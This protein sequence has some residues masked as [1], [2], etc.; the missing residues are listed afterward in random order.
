M[1]LFYCC[2]F[3]FL[4][5]NSTSAQTAIDWQNR[6]G[7]SDWES[8]KSIAPTDD[9]GYIMA[10]YSYSDDN[11]L[12][13]NGDHDFYVVKMDADGQLQWQKN[14]GGTAQ[15]NASDA[16]QTPDGG[17]IVVGRSM[18]NN[19]DMPGNQGAS[20][21][22]LVKLDSTGEMVWQR[23]YGSTG[24][25]EVHA[26]LVTS[27][28]GYVI[29][30]GAN[31]GNG[32]VTGHHG[33]LDAWV[34]KLDADGDVEWDRAYGG[35]ATDFGKD[36]KA[37][38]DGGYILLGT[39][40]ST[41]GDVTCGLS[42]S[43]MWVVKVD[44]TG[45]VQWDVC[46]GSPLGNMAHEIQ[47]TADGG[48]IGIGYVQGIGDDVTEVFGGKDI[49][50]FKLDSA[51]TLEWERSIG[52]AGDDQGHSI[53][54]TWDGGY[55]AVGEYAE[56]P[57]NSSG[58]GIFKLG[59]TG[60][61]EWSQF[62][63]LETNAIAF[64]VLALPDGDFVVAGQGDP[65]IPPDNGMDFWVVKLTTEYNNILGHVFIDLNSDGLHDS[66][67]PSLTNH[68]IHETTSDRF[69]LSDLN[70]DY[71]L[72]VLGPGTFPTSPGPLAHYS[73][74]PTVHSITFAGVNEVDANNDFAFQPDSM[75]HDLQISLV[76]ASAFRPG[77][78]AF[79]NVYFKNV[80][81]V[82]SSG[83]VVLIL[84]SLFTF[85]DAT[86]TPVT[87]AGDSIIWEIP[88][89]TPFETG[90]FVVEVSVDTSAVLGSIVF[91]HAIMQMVEPD[92]MPD[93]NTVS[94]PV[95]ITGAYDPNDIQVDLATIHIDDVPSA[96]WL[97]YL[98]RFQN[99]GND[100]AFTVKIEN[101]LTDLLDHGS[102]EFLGSSH[103]VEISYEVFNGKLWFE[104]ENILLPDS[105]TNEA[106]SHGFVRYRMRPRTELIVGDLIEN[107]VG[108]FFDLNAPVMT[109]IATTQIVFTTALEETA[110]TPVEITLFPNP[111]TGDL[112]L[113]Y[114]LSEASPIEIE[115]LAS[116]GQLIWRS[117]KGILFAGTHIDRISTSQ[118]PTGIYH[119]RIHVG[120]NMM[121]RK[122]VKM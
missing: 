82:P 50:I 4:L 7:G 52:A 91:S 122:L 61:V 87:N 77:F 95:T 53:V 83:T 2:F 10:G 118:F 68:L 70:G 6:F 12:T 48:Y 97:D 107:Q 98:I 38:S 49:W 5:V 15:D 102:F 14:I 56:E 47:L 21:I 112:D 110:Y 99:T 36:I 34:L 39:T 63:E 105:G 86:M 1:R 22:R 79:Y 69:T 65:A 40:S 108:I 60:A 88:E 64:Q 35:S 73:T 46:H 120:G 89:L 27:D 93:D 44:S 42:E 20:D 32:D 55:I 11:G 115:L 33:N 23:N 76:A 85:I 26:L 24:F 96:P 31:A 75:V 58:C 51:G 13:N 62:L 113:S 106:L 19:L 18:S 78:P 114:T 57:N 59:S 30:G 81:T 109:N 84:D 37:T 67:E 72:V 92:G 90:S 17:Y 9:G 117:D 119:L 74:V 66:N 43:R 28:S 101:P 41:N 111:T 104:F 116:T 100:T 54:Q 94:W 121:T 71:D 8:G 25:D 16:E 3:T 45:T 80:G 29:M 103:P